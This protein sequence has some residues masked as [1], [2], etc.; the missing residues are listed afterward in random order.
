MPLIENLS[1]YLP[2]SKDSNGGKLSHVESSDYQTRFQSDYILDEFNA[3]LDF[4]YKNIERLSDSWNL[5]KGYGGSSYP[6][7]VRD[8]FKKENRNP[9]EGN[10]IRQKVD[11]LAGSI[12]KNF[13]DVAYEPV[14]GDHS[15]LTRAV[16]ELMY[17][18]KEL[19]DWGSSYRQLVVDGLVYQGVEEIYINYDYS[20]YGNIGFRP[21]N[22][23]HILFDPT[24]L[25]NNSKELKRGFK[26]AYLT[27]K[28]LKETYSTK[29]DLIDDMISAMSLRATQYDYG[30][31]QKG[32]Q[33]YNLEEIYGDQYRVI[34]YHHMERERNSIEVVTATGQV[35]PE[36]ND[37]FKK[38]WAILNNVDLSMGVMKRSFDTDIYHITTVVP[39]LARELVLEDRPGLIQIGRLPFFPWSSGRINGVNSGIPDL[40]KSIQQT[41]NNRESLL[42]FAIATSAA[43][44]MFMDP[45]IVDGDEGKMSKIEENWNKPNFR[46][47]TG[48]GALASGRNF[49]KEL[50]R[51]NLDPQIGNEITRMIDLADMVSKQPAAMDARTENAGESGI[52]FARKQMQAEVTQ[53]LLI[54]S[55][56]Q[57][58]NDKGEAYLLLA[59]NLYSGVYRSFYSFGD[60]KA[61]ELNVPTVTPSGEVLD[62]DISQLPRMKV[63]ISQSPEGVTQRMVDRSID[64]DL[65]KVIGQDNPISRASIVKSVMNTLDS[66]K[67]DK[68]KYEESAELEYEFAKENLKTQIMGLKLKQTQ[69]GMQMQQMMQPQQG[70]SGQEQ[71]DKQQGQA[72]QKKPSGQSGNPAAGIT[73]NNQ[74]AVAAQ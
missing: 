68:S 62:N 42:D 63:I 41:Y 30:M 37:E 4:E 1:K 12:V 32:I 61:I 47:W 14:N 58:W 43:G 48:N 46:M 26:V 24:W 22:P 21:I 70:Q 66:S 19:L 2:F 10:I 33:H 15:Q 5:Y 60:K 39:G 6:E 11:G 71:I 27:P 72:P 64:M 65:L 28:D 50:P 31:P 29:S 53:T 40:L 8:K 7:K 17:I 3:A 51:S 34:E 20:P 25:S 38:K 36:G 13:F 54:K 45:D 67:A 73:G 44:G 18:D 9:F 52:L 69:A 35:V 74:A 49:F 23:G 59:K 57:L 55:L 56:E 16:T